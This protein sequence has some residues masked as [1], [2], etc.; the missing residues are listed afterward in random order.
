M[1]S[2]NFLKS[3][4][5]ISSQSRPYFAKNLY[6]TLGLSSAFCILA[7]S[8]QL[9]KAVQDHRLLRQTLNTVSDHHVLLNDI[10]R[11][12]IKHKAHTEQYRESIP[13]SSIIALVSQSV[14]DEVQLLDIEVSYLWPDL[15]NKPRKSRMKIP[16][17]TR[18]A[19]LLISGTCSSNE[20]LL[21]LASTLNASGFQSVITEDGIRQS[22]RTEMNEEKSFTI[23]AR[24]NTTSPAGDL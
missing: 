21:L 14:T 19:N 23:K 6:R 16:D 12:Q 8:V 20:Q 11:A 18:Q 5:S 3:T 9:W 13:P 24:S 17:Q 1:T 7:L 15:S 4:A 10:Q 2:I 22:N